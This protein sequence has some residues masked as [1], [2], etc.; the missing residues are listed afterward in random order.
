MITKFGWDNEETKFYNS[1]LGVIGLFGIMIGS[2]CGGP[3]I[4]KGRRFA[5]FWLFI[6]MSI[7]VLLT[8]FEV[9]ATIFIGRFITGFC[10]GIYQMCLIKA[11]NETV[12]SNLLG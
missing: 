3:F 7:G 6:P 2:T 9:Y 12:P 5:I 8:M 1:W 11:I 10:A 4:T